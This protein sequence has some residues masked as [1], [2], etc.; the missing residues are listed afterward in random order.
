MRLYPFSICL[1]TR[2]D[3]GMNKKKKGPGKVL[4]K[5]SKSAV[6]KPGNGY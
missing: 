3:S 4:F 5:S 2:I 1:F 6:V